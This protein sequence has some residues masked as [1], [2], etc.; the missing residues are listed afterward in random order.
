ML[1]NLDENHI[2]DHMLSHIGEV[3]DDAKFVESDELKEDLI[4]GI[5]EFC[6][7]SDRIETV[8]ADILV[9]TQAG[10]LMLLNGILTSWLKKG[11]DS[12]D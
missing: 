11:S 3:V 2:A 8:V 4:T 10:P 7:D 6:S 9:Q 12:N 5:T 1:L